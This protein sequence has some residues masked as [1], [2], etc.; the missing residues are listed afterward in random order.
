MN[1]STIS[2][3]LFFILLGFSI[4]GFGQDATSQN[5]DASLMQNRCT[6]NRALA[7]IA[8][9]PSWNGWGAG[10]ANARFQ[11]SA[12]AQLPAEQIGKLKLK[13]A[14]GFPGAKAVYGQP[15]IVAGRVFLGVDT[16]YVY[17][18]DART[19]CVY[20][21][22]KAEGGVRSAVSIGPARA[23]GQYLAYF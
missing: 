15:T 19:G 6:G 7:D 22:Y 23:A 11:S 20:W 17:S 16:G 14:F 9:Q 2:K 13:W 10:I 3:I 1:Q 5:G 4:S 18:L 21:S 12:A 8:G